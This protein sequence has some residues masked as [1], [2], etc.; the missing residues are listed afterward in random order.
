MKDRTGKIGTNGTLVVLLALAH[1]GCSTGL[2]FTG[3]PVTPMTIVQNGKPTAT[4]VVS[5]DAGK[6]VMDAVADLQLYIEKMSGAKPPISH[7]GDERGNLILVGRMPQVD[8]LVPNLDAL[9]LGP[10][11]VVIK[12]LDGKLILTGKSDGYIR[13][14]RHYIHHPGKV[15]VRADFGT[16][17]AVYSFLDLLGCRWYTPGDDGEFVPSK[18]TITVADLDIVSKPDFDGRWINPTFSFRATGKKKELADRLEKDYAAWLVRNR[19]G[20]NLYHQEHGMDT[21]LAK[22][23][24]PG[25]H[26]EYFALIDGKRRTDRS[27]QFCMSNPDLLR[28]V[29]KNLDTRL[30]RAIPWR[31]TPAGQYDGSGWCQCDNCKAYYGAKM[32]TYDKRGEARTVGQNVGAQ[33]PNVAHGYLKFV[34]ALAKSTEATHPDCLITYYA[35][36]NIPGFPDVKPRDNVMP[37]ICHIAPDNEA[38][39]RQTLA[40]AGMSRQLYYYGYMGYR[41]ALPKLGFGRDIRWCHQNKGVAMY[42]EVD[43]H[44][45]VNLLPLYLAARTLWDSNADTKQILAEFYRNYYGPAAAPMRSFWETFDAACRKDTRDWDTHYNYPAALTPE[46]ASRCRGYLTRAGA[47]AADPV[48]KRRIATVGRYWLAAEL[49]VV[50]N[51]AMNKWRGDKTAEN[52]Q[53][54]RKTVNATI[55]YVKSVVGEFVISA[56]LPMLNGWLGELDKK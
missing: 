43:E 19:T 50:A 47:L 38:W 40:W 11:G 31:S 51:S 7:S 39:R 18:A 54:A 4:I 46:V 49:H 44:S 29:A 45:P 9:D 33:Q 14:A 8:A 32:F 52:N 34:N 10:D 48:V 12:L 53:V 27:A 16:P 3:R 2:P 41:I 28:E 37:G 1:V 25:I 17:N 6:P 30:S 55:E 5:A 42:L 20:A 22:Y 21:L 36:Y 26:P 24:Y 56:R 23:H 35:L 15:T 13:T